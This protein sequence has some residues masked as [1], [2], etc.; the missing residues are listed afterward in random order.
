MRDKRTGT[1]YQWPS[2]EIV[3]QAQQIGCNLVP[4]GFVEPKKGKLTAEEAR[5]AGI[6][7]RIHFTKLEGLIQRNL[8]HPKVRCFLFA[9]LLWKAHLEESNSVN[10]IESLHIRCGVGVV[11]ADTFAVAVVVVAH[12]APA[13]PPRPPGTSST[14]WWRKT[15]P[16]GRRRGWETTWSCCCGR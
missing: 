7:W 12:I 1:I 8:N 5:E 13:P 3:S 4:V 2:R 16:C 6:Q 11:G 15:R 10:S 14:G 9:L